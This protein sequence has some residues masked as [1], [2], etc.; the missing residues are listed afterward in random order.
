MI[1][2][3]FLAWM[4]T[5]GSQHREEAAFALAKLWVEPEMDE[6][7]REAA[8]AAMTM[9]LDD[10]DPQV[11]LALARATAP[12][13]SAPRHIVLSLAGDEPEIAMEVLARSQ[14]FLDGEL[15]DIINSGLCQQ[16]A[17]IACRSGVSPVVANAI[18][19]HGHVDACFAL[20]M[21]KG[22]Q[23]SPQSLHLLAQRHGTV[24]AIRRLL[25]RRSNVLASTRL[26][27][28]DKLGEALREEIAATPGLS[29]TRMEQ[30]LSD[31]AE[32]AII[33]YASRV[34][35]HE[36][37][38]ISAALIEAGRMTAAFLL[39]CICMG[40]IALFAGSLA[41]LAAMPVKRVE[42]ALDAGKRSAFRAFY[43]KSG[44]PDS[45]FEV[46]ASAVDIW[47]T[48]L[49][50]T[51]QAD[52]TRMTWLVTRELLSTYRGRT[53]ATVDALL[54]L[55]RRLAAEAARRNARNEVGRITKQVRDEEQR[56]LEQAERD[57]NELALEKFPVIEVPMPVLA[58]FA[59]HF[60]EEL[61]E[62]ED[63][64]AMGLQPVSA[65][66]TPA[67]TSIA[68][69][70]MPVLAAN[71]DSPQ[72]AGLLSVDMGQAVSRAKAA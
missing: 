39:R 23:T 37:L 45:A 15:V 6:F 8:E 29:S 72:S 14:V 35:E 30:L 52:S 7:E 55:L 4:E 61:V 49:S 71:D 43:I 17:A 51:D 16:Q 67:G 38:Q 65:G 32:K 58:D 27:L 56:L 69:E 36:I 60:A 57:P 25:L 53:D 12:L 47:R 42:S 64:L 54:V 21:N 19:E 46:F 24:T 70:L 13:D 1:V 48:T 20:L 59:L 11:R 31:H 44:L 9:L 3:R 26:L 5:A 40:N 34:D 41:Q 68:P 33:A 63:Q 22:A 62:L 28:I 66:E 18:A 2:A 50:T 10:A